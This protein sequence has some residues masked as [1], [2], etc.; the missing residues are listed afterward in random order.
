MVPCVNFIFISADLNYYEIF[1]YQTFTSMHI[2][3][4]H[5]ILKYYDVI[6]VQHNFCTC[7][8]QLKKCFSNIKSLPEDWENLVNDY[9]LSKLIKL[10]NFLTKNE[11]DVIRH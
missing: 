5:S 2:W 3:Y 10:L 1:P 4:Y 7:C 11:L 6:V 9:K 8:Y